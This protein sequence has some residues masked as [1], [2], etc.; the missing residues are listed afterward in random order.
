MDIKS[1]KLKVALEAFSVAV[2]VLSL[3]FVGLEVNESTRAT[4][5]AT[6]AETTATIAEW[7]T[8][9]GSDQQVSSVFRRFITDPQSL[10]LEEQYQATMTLHSLMLILQSSFYLEEEGTLSPQIRHSMTK[11]ILSEPGVR[12]YWEQRKAIFVNE[13][14]IAFIEQTLSGENTHSKDLYRSPDT[15]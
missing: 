12:F 6:A 15:Q 9:L 7:Y 2:V 4:R 13:D 1:P 11:A 14:F 3:I 10:N 8:A 5:S